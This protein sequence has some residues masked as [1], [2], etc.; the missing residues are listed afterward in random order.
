MMIN[1]TQNVKSVKMSVS[2]VPMPMVVMSV[3]LTEL[4]KLQSVHV[5]PVPMNAETPNVVLVLHN[6]LPVLDLEKIVMSVLP[7]LPTNHHNV[8]V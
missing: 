4:N 2:L 6:V 8:H 7:I 3:N 1:I 5:Q